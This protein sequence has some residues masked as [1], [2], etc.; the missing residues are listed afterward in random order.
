MLVPAG[1]Q[2]SYAYKVYVED[3]EKVYTGRASLLTKV[4]GLSELYYNTLLDLGV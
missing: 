1:A 4:A 3:V 2:S